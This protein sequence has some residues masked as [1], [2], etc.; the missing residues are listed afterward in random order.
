TSL[1]RAI[2]AARV[3]GTPAMRISPAAEGQ[4]TAAP[5]A[6]STTATRRNVVRLLCLSRRTASACMPIVIMSCEAARV[7]RSASETGMGSSDDLISGAIIG[8][9]Q[10]AA[11]FLLRHSCGA[12]K[13]QLFSQGG[14]YL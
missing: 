10:R 4:T 5:G 14:Y 9:V 13:R 2:A 6:A 7:D 8:A 12:L 11:V 1:A 3:A